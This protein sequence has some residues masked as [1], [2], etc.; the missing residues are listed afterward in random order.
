MFTLINR[1]TV[2]GDTEEF[3]NV[4]EGLTGFMIK[5]PGF[6]THR[7]Y[8]SNKDPQIY[9][10]ISEWDDPTGHRAAMGSE[11]F[12]GWVQKLMKLTTADPAPFTVIKEYDAT[13][14]AATTH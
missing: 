2:T 7:L 12:R 6:R 13:T 8:H 4:L 1:F 9:V 5:Q 11:D 10:E 3:E 14:D